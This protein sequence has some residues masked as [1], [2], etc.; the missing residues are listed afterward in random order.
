VRVHVYQEELTGDVEL[1]T[2]TG[3]VGEDGEP[4]TFIGVRFWLEGSDALHRTEH[5]DDRPAVT[6]WARPDAAGYRTLAS[7]LAAAAMLL[8]HVPGIEYPS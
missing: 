2:K 6:L 7:T 5:D 3:V 1:I 8:G 4:T